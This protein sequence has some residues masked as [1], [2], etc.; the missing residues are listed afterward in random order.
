[1]LPSI[2]SNVLALKIEASMVAIT[3]PPPPMQ[4]G[5]LTWPGLES[6]IYY[7]WGKHANHYT[8]TV[9]AEQFGFNQIVLY[10]KKKTYIF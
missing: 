1:M 10:F 4:F 2:N 8:T 7:T 5:S 3:L 6:T 9:T